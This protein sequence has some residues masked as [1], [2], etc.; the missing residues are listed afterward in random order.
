MKVDKNYLIR[1]TPLL[2]IIGNV[3]LKI[4][5][6]GRVSSLQLWLMKVYRILSQKKFTSLFP[7][8]LS[9]TLGR[10]SAFKHS[11][12]NEQC[13]KLKFNLHLQLQTITI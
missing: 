8:S 4:I 7:S 13:T 3:I 12:G 2:L 11:A 9:A 5:F 6:I 10:H 1:I